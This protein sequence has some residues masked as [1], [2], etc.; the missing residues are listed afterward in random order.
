L[1]PIRS[2]N[3]GVAL[4]A[5]QA[6][7]ALWSGVALRTGVALWTLRAGRSLLARSAV[8][9]RVA[10]IALRAGVACGSLRSGVSRVALVTLGTGDRNGA[11]LTDDGAQR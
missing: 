4:V 1:R 3:A 10:G 9:T 2:G 6:P 5:D 11:V 8:E 7:L